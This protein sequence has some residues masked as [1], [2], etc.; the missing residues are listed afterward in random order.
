MADFSLNDPGRTTFLD[1]KHF[2][3]IKKVA[4]DKESFEYIVTEHLRMSG[5][6]WALTAMS[7]LGKNIHEDMNSEEII[8]WVLKCQDSSG[9]YVKIDDVLI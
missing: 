6:Y 7:L 2:K 5:V 8:D 4:N 9:G 3:Y 1:D